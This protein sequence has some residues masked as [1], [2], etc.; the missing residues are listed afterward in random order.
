MNRTWKQQIAVF[1]THYQQQFNLIAGA[2]LGA[3]I[4]LLTESK[5]FLYIIVTLAAFAYLL[6]WI[7]IKLTFENC[8]YCGII[9]SKSRKR[10][11]TVN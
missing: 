2:F 1:N 6:N 11:E 9:L 5:V 10:Q 3:A 8:P 7:V 4:S